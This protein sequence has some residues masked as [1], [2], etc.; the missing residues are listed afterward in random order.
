M[1][2]ERPHA[3][4]FH[5]DNKLLI[6]KLKILGLELTSVAKSQTVN[7]EKYIVD[8]YERSSMKYEGVFMQKVKAKTKKTDLDID[9]FWYILK[10]DQKNSNLA[11]EVL[12]PEAPNS[13]V[14]YNIIKTNKNLELPYFRLLKK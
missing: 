8:S 5:N 12:E 10:M 13:F 6:K 9:K 1:T 2:R 14:S 3:Y 4:L 11:I 7:V